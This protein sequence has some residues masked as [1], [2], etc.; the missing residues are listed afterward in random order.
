MR[1][2]FEKNLGIMDEETF[3]KLQTQ[4]IMIV[5]LGGLGGHI[6]NNLVRLGVLNLHLVDPDV[7]ELTNLNRQLFSSMD[8][9][10]LA[11]TEVITKAIKQINPD[12][13]VKTHQKRIQDVDDEYLHQIDLLVDAVDDISTKS[14]LEDIAT[15][16]EIPLLHGAIAGWYG[17]VGLIMPHTSILKD[18]YQGE[19]QGME[20]ILGSPTFTPAVIAGIMTSEYLKYISGSNQTLINRIMMIDLLNLDQQIL[21]EG[22]K[23]KTKGKGK[24]LW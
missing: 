22:N 20:K 4:R 3:G 1:Q 15:Q 2:L 23:T 8:V 5:G 7:F 19:Q 14:Y 18:L 24:D 21:F 9:I 16:H 13:Q 10:G 11:K 12:L 17:Q 6:A